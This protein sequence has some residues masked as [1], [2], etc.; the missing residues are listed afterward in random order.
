MTQ[1]PDPTQARR[2]TSV[3]DALLHLAET[4]AAHTHLDSLLPAIVEL[5]ATMTGSDACLLSLWDED[6]ARF[7]PATAYGLPPRLERLFYRLPFSPGDVPLIDA[8][9]RR[10]PVVAQAS[11]PLLPPALW[12]RLSH[13]T[14]LGV[15][16]LRRD[17]AMGGLILLRERGSH[18]DGDA[19]ALAQMLGHHTVIALENARL[20]QSEQTRRRQLQ[21][22]QKTIAALSAELLPD[23]LLQLIAAQTA[24][25][26]DALAAAVLVWDTAHENLAVRAHHGLPDDFARRLRLPYKRLLNALERSPGADIL[27][28]DD[29]KTPTPGKGDVEILSAAPGSSSALLCALQLGG[30]LNGA[31]LI[32]GDRPRRFRADEKA[33]ARTLAQQATIAIENTQLYTAL[34]AERERLSALSTRLTQTQE[35]ER[36]RIARELHDEAGQA[37]T[38]VRLQLDFVNSILPPDAPSPVREQINQAHDLVG[39][40]LQEIRRISMDLRPSLLDD[41]GLTPA[42]RWQCDH[43]SR[44]ANLAARFESVGDVR[45]L[46]ADVETTVYR[47]AQEALT[48]V[49]RHAQ[50]TSVSISLEYENDGLRLTI[51][52]DGRGFADTADQETGLGLIGMQ[53]R[54]STIG[55]TLHIDP[56]PGAGSTLRIE[57]PF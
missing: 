49:A 5:A 3:T 16:L 1:H 35:A 37:L 45:R 22:L 7:L 46:D 43:F 11:G 34:Q 12:R 27:T 10:R 15:P 52:D 42:L 39:R 41:L 18:F 25:M 9:M 50:A 31:L 8:M 33:L 53:E 26:F 14:L 20:F 13:R 4:I 51:A 6:R 56:R 19:L 29:F 55:G 21:G 17:Q 24:A 36:A 38:A 32:Y 2:E 48:N 23:P 54:L 28:I 47:A 44:H 40:T 57:V 30:Q